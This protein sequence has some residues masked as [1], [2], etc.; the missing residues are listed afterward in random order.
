[1]WGELQRP[2]NILKY[3]F[4]DK[5]N[6]KNSTIY[7]KVSVYEYFEKFFGFKNVEEAKQLAKNFKIFDLFFNS[8][9]TR[10]DDDLDFSKVKDKIKDEKLILNHKEFVDIYYKMD[11]DKINDN[12]YYEIDEY[13]KIQGETLNP[14]LGVYFYNRNVK[15]DEEFAKASFVFGSTAITFDTK[16]LNTYLM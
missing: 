7:L 4:A 6:A 2:I 5:K 16:K 3:E 11:L 15:I 10:F 9:M 1:M 13:H 14:S 8:Q 12:N